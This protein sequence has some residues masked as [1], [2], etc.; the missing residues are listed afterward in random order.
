MSILIENPWPL[1]WVLGAVGVGCLVALR[2]TQRGRYLVLA[3]GCVAAALLLLAV[4]ALVLTDVERIEH[5]LDELVSASRRSDAD[6][7]LSL[8]TDDVSL[9]QGSS[10]P[11]TPPS[12]ARRSLEGTIT[13]SIIHDTLDDV[14]F[15]FIHIDNPTITAGQITRQGRAEFRLYAKGTVHSRGFSFATD[16]EGSDWSLG[17]RE[18]GGQWKVSRI[19]AV[20]LPRGASLPLAAPRTTME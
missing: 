15:D 2:I 17:F 1:V 9:T 16:A 3:F 5:V 19:T 8:L 13:R 14:R 18:V 10:L 7:A 20:R 4:D 12:A 11:D 6:A